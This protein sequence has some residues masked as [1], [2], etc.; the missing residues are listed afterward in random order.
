MISFERA[1]EL[2]QQ[3]S[4]RHLLIGNGFSRA[5]CNDIFNYQS[6]FDRGD[7]SKVSP[8]L[9]KLSTLSI[10]EISRR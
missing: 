5:L 6:L 8:N 4:H 9:K 1:L 10:L 3:A 7:F 2:A